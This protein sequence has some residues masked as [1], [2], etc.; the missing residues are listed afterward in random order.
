LPMLSREYA[1]FL[2][3]PSNAIEP[4]KSAVRSQGGR[5]S[6]LSH[7]NGIAEALSYY[8]GKAAL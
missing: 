8:L 6:E 2:A 7:G 5:V 1:H 3:S 4:V